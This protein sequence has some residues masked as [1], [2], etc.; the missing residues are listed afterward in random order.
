M[1]VRR[2]L[3]RVDVLVNNAGLYLETTGPTVATG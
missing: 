2:W 1:H 3:G